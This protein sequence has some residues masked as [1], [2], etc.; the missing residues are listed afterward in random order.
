MLKSDLGLFTDI[1]V[2]RTL[3]SSSWAA[4]LDVAIFIA[5]IVVNLVTVLC[6]LGLT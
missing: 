4:D 6:Y 2:N 1:K 5:V 3:R